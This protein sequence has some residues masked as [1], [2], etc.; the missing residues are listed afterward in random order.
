MSALHKIL[1][2]L[3]PELFRTIRAK[4]PFLNAICKKLTSWDREKAVVIPQGVAKGLLFR[5][6][7]GP[8]EYALGIAEPDVQRACQRLVQPGMIA[9]DIGANVG[10][11]S[12]LLGRLVGE[13]GYVY[14]FE[15]F[16]EA[17]QAAQENARLNNMRNIEVI[18]AAV[19]AENGEAEFLLGEG[20]T[21][22]H[23]AT[24]ST[25]TNERRQTCIKVPVVAI[26][27]FVLQQGHQPPHFLKIDVE[28]GE[29]AVLQGMKKVLQQ[30]RPVLLVEM[31]GR[32][33]EVAETLNEVNY[34]TQVIDEDKPLEEASWNV[35]IVAWHS[36]HP[37]PISMRADEY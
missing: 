17:S 3:P 1:S 35:H 18:Q 21:M 20:S 19:S 11:H 25:Y 32:N 7:S 9:Y 13:Q 8:L 22:G 5:R 16:P 4:H 30:H 37:M 14:A 28:G 27:H 34:L 29:V 24:E 26:D 33:K 10:F 6:S 36:S 15:P 23:L 31:H 12:V 2:C